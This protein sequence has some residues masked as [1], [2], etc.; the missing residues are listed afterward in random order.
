MLSCWN[1][2]KHKCMANN[3][4]LKCNVSMIH[5]QLSSYPG[6]FREP[7]WKSMGLPEIY[8]HWAYWRLTARSCEV[9]KLRDSGLY[10]FNHS[11]I[12]QAPQQQCCQD[13]CQI[14]EWYNH[15]NIQSHGFETSRDPAVRRR[16]AECGEAQSTLTSRVT[17]MISQRLW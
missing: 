12:W 16:S 10:F 17:V 8:R 11:K 4:T 13:A 9:S 7:H 15:Y 3:S 2:I 14:S 1:T 5:G 6:Y